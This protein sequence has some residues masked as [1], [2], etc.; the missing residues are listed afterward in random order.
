M[1][2]GLARVS[3]G[4]AWRLHWVSMRILSCNPRLYEDGGCYTARELDPEWETRALGRGIA[5]VYPSYEYER[6]SPVIIGSETR[7][8]SLGNPLMRAQLHRWIG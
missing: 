4:A 5:R 3:G 8:K 1:I 2:A 6:R 7:R